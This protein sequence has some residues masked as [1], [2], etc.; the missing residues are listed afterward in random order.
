LPQ[1]AWHSRIGLPLAGNITGDWGPKLR[2]A[3]TAQGDFAQGAVRRHRNM[4]GNFQEVSHL[5]Q[6]G[7][8][9]GYFAGGVSVVGY[10]GQ[11]VY[12]AAVGEAAV[13]PT[14]RS[15]TMDT[16]FDLASLTKPIATTTALMLLVENN[17]V[18]LDAPINA[19]VPAF[20]ASG[21]VFPTLRQLL[22]HCS[23]LPA[24]RP[25]YQAIDPSW[26]QADRRRAVHA[27][28]HREPLLATPGTAVHY[29]D[30]G[31]ILLGELVETVTSMP[32]DEFCRREIFAALE[33]ADM[34]F[35]NLARPQP[36]G[37][38]YASTENCPWRGRV[39]HGEVHDE[40]A[41]IMG[42]VAGHAGLFGTAHQVWQFAQGLLDGRNGQPWLVSTA[43]IRIFTTRQSTPE[44]S[45]WGL[46]WD[47]P[48]PGKSSAGR[49]F[50]PTAIGH[51]GYTGTSLW[52]DPERGVIVV[53]L[54]N[55]VHPSRQREGIRAFRPLL[56]DAVMQALKWG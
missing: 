52:I 33:L 9:G 28:I 19:Y 41:W 46:G 29:S 18:D 1:A 5:L 55:R 54:T 25:Y 35:L 56:H 49:Y 51:L 17:R 2:L 30:A 36:A 23:G 11:L 3:L 12:E 43:T 6:Q 40:N 37:I 47:T 50:A 26:P 10:Q 53:F 13:L 14:R 22:S 34:G 21:N 44:G 24:W 48:T 15:M 38:R 42:G 7:V 39:L 16:V 8:E 27:A 32:L 31:F 4:R 45:T 20:K